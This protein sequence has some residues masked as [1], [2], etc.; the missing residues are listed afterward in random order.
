MSDVDIRCSDG[1]E[2]E[3][4]TEPQGSSWRDFSILE[5]WTKIDIACALLVVVFVCEMTTGQANRYAPTLAPLVACIPL[6]LVL[7][8]RDALAGDRASR[9]AILFLGSGLVSAML[10]AAP[11]AALVGASLRHTS[12]LVFVGGFCAFALASVRAR[13]AR[14]WLPVPS[15]S[16]CAS[17]E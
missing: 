12:W 14:D 6:G 10:S 11:I 2:G 13:M 17:A 16:R 3:V 15:S 5:S 8:V 1:I 7:L 9:L 4:E